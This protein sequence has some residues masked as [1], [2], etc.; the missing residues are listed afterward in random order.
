MR[1]QE[2]FT[3]LTLIPEQCTPRAN[4][5]IAKKWKYLIPNIIKVL[6]SQFFLPMNPWRVSQCR[7]HS[8]FPQYIPHL[9]KEETQDKRFSSWKDTHTHTHTH[10][11]TYKHTHTRRFLMSMN[12]CLKKLWFFFKWTDLLYIN[13]NFFSPNRNTN[14]QAAKCCNAVPNNLSVVS[15][16][17]IK[18]VHNLRYIIYHNCIIT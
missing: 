1:V 7:L 18:G 3:L 4:F 13:R 11:H 15:I 5:S 14:Y 10:T 8:H 9:S 6:K 17:Y 16:W 2:K 12:F